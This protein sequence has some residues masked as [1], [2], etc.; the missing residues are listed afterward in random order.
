M[1]DHHGLVELDEWLLDEVFNAIFLSLQGCLV[2]CDLLNHLE[3]NLKLDKWHSGRLDYVTSFDEAFLLLVL[4]M[5]EQ[6]S[7]MADL[8]V[9]I[10]IQF[11]SGHRQVNIT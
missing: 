7:H 11:E 8:V 10:S 4:Q 1:E 9:N 5:E 3:V 6:S 2:P